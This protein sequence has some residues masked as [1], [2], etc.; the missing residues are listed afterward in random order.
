MAPKKQQK[1]KKRGV[2]FK[3]IKRKIGRKLP[4]PKNT[5]NTEIKSKAII[6]P[7]QSVA[8]EKQ[9]FVVSKKGLTL[10]ELLEQT[11][12]HN[13]KARR[14]IRDLLSNNPMELWSHR[15]YIIKTLTKCIGDVDEVVR[16]KV[17][18]LFKIVIFPGC[19]EDMASLL[20][21]MMF[22]IFYA[23]TQLR[24]E[25][26][27]MAFKFL[28][29]LLQFH[30]PCFF[31]HADK[32]LEN[33]EDILMK[34]RLFIQEKGKLKNA[35][36]GL[37]RCLTLLPND[38]VEGHSSEKNVAERRILHGYELEQPTKSAAFSSAVA[39]LS[40]LVPVLVNCFQ[41]F[42][43]LVH[44]TSTLDAQSFES[45]ISILESINLAV[46]FFIYQSPEG[47][48]QWILST[49]TRESDD[50]A[51]THITKTLL[52]ALKKLLSLFPLNPTH[53][54]SEKDEDRYFVLNSGI[55]EIFLRC[56]QKALLEEVCPNVG[57][58]D[59]FLEFI[60]S[61][62]L[63]KI[64]SATKSGKATWNKH[65]LSLITFVPKLVIQVSYFR[66]G[67]RS[68]LLQAFT[69]TFQDCNP[70]SSIKF[71]CISLLEEMLIP[72][73]DRLSD[74]GDPEMS[75]FR[76][77]WMRVLPS[78]LLLLDDKHPSSTQAVLCLMLRVE[79][80]NLLDNSLEKEY[81]DSLVR[82]YRVYERKENAHSGPFLR[83]PRG[84]QEI[85]ISCI[86][87]LPDLDK[88][89][90]KSILSYCLCPQV[91]PDTLFRTVGTL[92][93]AYSKGHI[94]IADQI[95]FLITL[96]SS[97]KVFPEKIN[98]IMVTDNKNSNRSTFKKL[99]SD[100]CDYLSPA[101]MGDSSLVLQILESITVHQISLKLP[102]DNTCALLSV[103]V[104][105]DTKPTRLSEQSVLTLSDFLAG[106][107]IDIMH[108][109]PVDNREDYGEDD[110]KTTIF[111]C[112]CYLTPIFFLFHRSY[113]LGRLSFKKIMSLISEKTD[114]VC[115][116]AK[117]RPSQISAKIEAK[118]GHKNAYMTG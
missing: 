31:L 17:Y 14:G 50:T 111:T 66:S 87:Y 21:S 89:F 113:E 44:S 16:E 43:P 96:L 118:H 18:Q 7:E 56:S 30:P 67:W 97:F 117:D 36:S 108:C 24:I 112:R 74:P 73:S 62:L 102:L 60:E 105:L 64:C 54:F 101:W 84:C 71:A 57:L 27:L 39:K 116:Y 86:Y 37:V 69:Q 38:N 22:Y 35:L 114:G 52:I 10:K 77:T 41:D 46:K 51:L 94:Q 103:L 4:P 20:P 11:S 90:L 91:E 88:V 5:T 25:I 78:L 61:A 12:H 49:T 75:N 104:S 34:N 58:L 19:E 45:M 95:S 82:F 28:D 48:R 55:T 23:M 106:Y 3:K 2:D 32:I 93:S 1:Q 110:S 70:G 68:R 59:S 107:I 109:I 26:R 9:G 63:G 42:V 72:G 76:I 8:A 15:F 80:C 13:N 65:V 81:R 83:L 115:Q 6:L 33:Y 29:L 99:T 47:K 79:Q 53:H 85:S 100:V 92:G 98:P 40:D